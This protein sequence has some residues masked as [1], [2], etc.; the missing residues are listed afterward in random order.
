MLK[1]LEDN[2]SYDNKVEIIGDMEQGYWAY[3]LTR[4]L[5]NK[6]QLYT[7][8]GQ[9][10]ITLKMLNAKNDI[11]AADYIIYFNRT[12]YYKVLQQRIHELGD[13]IF[14]N[15]FGGIVKCK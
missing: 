7:R 13:I 10:G 2:I 4:Y 11:E 6:E 8:K 9:N 1:Y 3:T 5:N 12:D 15:N 14:E